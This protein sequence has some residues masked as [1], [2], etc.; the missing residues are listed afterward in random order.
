M[1]KSAVSYKITLDLFAK[2][3]ELD[4]IAD[5]IVLIQTIFAKISIAITQLTPLHGDDELHNS[6]FFLKQSYY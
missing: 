2:F 1:A 6:Y 3:S 5:K 4:H